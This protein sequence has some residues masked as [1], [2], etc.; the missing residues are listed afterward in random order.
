MD[1]TI[2]QAKLAEDMFP[3]ESQFRVALNQIILALGRTCADET[4]LDEEAFV[5]LA[6]IRER[7]QAIRALVEASPAESWVSPDT[8]IDYTLPNNMRFVLTAAEYIRDWMLPN[9][10]FH[11]TMAY[12]LL[13]HNGLAIGK[14]DFVGHMA[15]YARAPEA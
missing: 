6:Q 9:F 1:D 12:A 15:R 7:I 14:G 4:P 2:L 5:S 13:R 3:L 10:Y 8:V 11:T